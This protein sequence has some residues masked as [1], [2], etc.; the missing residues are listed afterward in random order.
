MVA[1]KQLPVFVVEGA[2]WTCEVA[3][4]EMNA[5]FIHEEQAFEAA[6]KAVET[7]K[8]VVRNDTFE[9]KDPSGEPPYIGL[10]LFTYLKGSD[11]DKT[12]IYVPAH[13][14]LANGGFYRDSHIIFVNFI[15]HVEEIKRREATHQQQLEKDIRNFETL[16][17]ELKEK[18]SKKKTPKK[19]KGKDK[20]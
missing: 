17:K 5:D 3:L 13:V 8:G 1:A 10:A 19:K 9:V 15:K 2:N 14:A 4:D 18:K 20:P 12:G 7:F 16:Q 11:P 6:T